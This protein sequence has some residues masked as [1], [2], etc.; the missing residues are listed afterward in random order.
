ME[1]LF[2]AQDSTED[3]GVSKGFALNQGWLPSYVETTGYIIPTMFDCAVRFGW[4]DCHER[5]LKMAEW[6]L[7]NQFSDGS[8]PGCQ[9]ET[10][11]TPLVFDTGMVIFG[12]LRTYEETKDKRFKTASQKAGNWLIDIQEASGEWKQF[13][14]NN[15]PRA[16]H[17][18]V[19][20]ALLRLSVVTNQ[21]KYQRAAERN[22]Q[23][24]MRQQHSNGWFENNS[25]YGGTK[26][27]THTIAYATRGLLE[28]GIITQE[29]AFIH[30]A[31]KTAVA[32]C[33]SQRSDGSLP[34]SFNPDWR[35]PPGFSCLSG[36]AQA[37][38]IWLRLFE[39]TGK[40]RFLTAANRTVKFLK[41]MQDLTT[42]YKQIRG[43]I[44]S[45]HPI[46]T[47]YMKFFYSNWAI[48]FFI[49]LLLLQSDINKT[50]GN[51]QE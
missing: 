8:F 37:A 40:A 51:G 32:L 7:A 27:I 1:W 16:Y 33:T 35:G 30:A 44:K 42:R 9:I 3:D 10:G 20:W 29:S 4:N 19:A 26:A 17:A 43:G 24:V 25:F 50:Y 6:E 36:N 11:G 28:G 22:L 15:Q 13:T 21:D 18:R 5:A 23:W 12:L 34:G 47:G 45:S 49:D 31:E 48:K 2:R 14:L 38:I 46:F 39:V 41:T